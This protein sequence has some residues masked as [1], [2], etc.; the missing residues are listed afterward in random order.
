MGAQQ[1]IQIGQ[2]GAVAW[3]ARGVAEVSAS[4]PERVFGKGKAV[5]RLVKDTA[6]TM[7]PT[8][9][10]LAKLRPMPPNSS[11]TM[12]MDTKAPTTG[13]HRGMVEGTLKASNSPVTTAD[14]SWMESG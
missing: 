2:L 1:Q 8:M 5:I 11:L 9:A 3:A 12:T 6:S 14:R 4:T 10:G 13:I 7:R